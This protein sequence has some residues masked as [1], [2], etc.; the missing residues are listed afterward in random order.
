MV[1]ELYKQHV[2]EKMQR[3]QEILQATG[4][5]ELVIG[6]GETKMQFQDDMP[7]SFKANP[8]FREWAPLAT[9]AGCYLQIIAGASKPRLFLLTAEDIWHTAPESLPPG[10]E[11]S[12]EIIE[13]ETVDEVK[14]CLGANAA[15]INETN[16]L[17]AVAE[18]WKNDENGAIAKAR[19]CARLTDVLPQPIEQPSKPLWRAHQRYRLLQ[20]TWQVATAARARCPMAL[21]P[22]LMNMQL[23]C[24]IIISLS[25][26]KLP[27][28]F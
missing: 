26:R 17:E 19:E 6:S 5:G 22:G 9:R 12:F 13:Y 2:A 20:P 7:Y 10:F 25:N 8:Y 16:T 24:T 11:Q 28:A 3:F 21:L 14:K 27:V 15:F 4:F 23:F 1:V 18:H